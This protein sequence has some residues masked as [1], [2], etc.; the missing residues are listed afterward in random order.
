MK[1]LP[2]QNGNVSYTKKNLNLNITQ[3]SFRSYKIILSSVDT[4]IN[5]YA[6]VEEIPVIFSN[7]MPVHSIFITLFII[8]V[9]H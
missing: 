6:C 3:T 8:F 7:D 2:K 4:K 9:F 5:I 1:L